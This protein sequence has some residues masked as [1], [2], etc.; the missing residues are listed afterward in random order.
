LHWKEKIKPSI[1]EGFFFDNILWTLRWT[2]ATKPNTMSGSTWRERDKGEKEK[3][4]TRKE[5]AGYSG[6][7][8]MVVLQNKKGSRRG[9][10]PQTDTLT[11]RKREK[12]RKKEKDKLLSRKRQIVKDWNKKWTTKK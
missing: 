3:K 5:K 6:S 7:V 9:S 12:K 4:I 1:V 8:K 2:F 10:S 11:I